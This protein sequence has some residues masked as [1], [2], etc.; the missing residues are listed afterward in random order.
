MLCAF[1]HAPQIMFPHITYAK[2]LNSCLM[3]QYLFNVV[4]LSLYGGAGGVVCGGVAG[5]GGLLLPRPRLLRRGEPPDGH[6]PPTHLPLQ[7]EQ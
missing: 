2:K 4:C 5:A 7:E 1:Q 3:Y 6:L